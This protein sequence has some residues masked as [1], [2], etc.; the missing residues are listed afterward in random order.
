MNLSFLTTFLAS[1][2]TLILNLATNAALALSMYVALRTGVFSVAS[3]GAMAIGAYASALA[4]IHLGT[5]FPVSMLIGVVLALIV[6]IP[7]IIPVLRLNYMYLALATLSF[8]EIIGFVLIRWADVTGGPLGLVGIPKIV[9]FAHVGLYL[10]VL[11]LWFWRLERGVFG[12]LTVAVQTDQQVV[13]SLGL[14]PGRVKVYGFLTSIAIGGSVGTLSA[15]FSRF[16]AP[17]NFGF[18]VTISTL[19]YAVIGGLGAFWGPVAGALLLTA[20]PELLRFLGTFRLVVSSLL[21]LVVA[22]Y[23]PDGLVGLVHRVARVL[24]PHRASL[25]EQPPDQPTAHAREKR[26]WE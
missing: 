26:A 14:E 6:S 21:V 1:Y 22:I 11:L 10:L 17:A 19:S 4:T 25:P 15:H 24:W 8:N 9:G 16:I 7:L 13:S 5:P 20:A 12:R 3:I 23:Y 2:Q 18:D